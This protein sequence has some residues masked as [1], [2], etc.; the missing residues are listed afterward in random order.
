[1]RPLALKAFYD[2]IVAEQPQ[3]LLV[4]GDIGES[5]SVVRFV[6]E[7]GQLAPI[8]FVLGNH[9]YYR[10]SIRRVRT[11]VAELCSTTPKLVWLT[12]AEVVELALFLQRMGA[13]I[14]LS[15]DRRIVIEGVP[16]LRG[17]S[18]R[19]AGDRLD[20]IEVRRRLV[21]VRT[22]NGVE[23]WVDANLLLSA[24]QM[25]ELAH[26]NRRRIAIAA[27]ADRGRAAGRAGPGDQRRAEHGRGHQNAEP[28]HQAARLSP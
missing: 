9:D 2:Q 26:A 13:H 6:T 3:V 24:Q 16:R 12:S 18:T 27:D 23:G 4:T 19:L 15:P 10:G 17:A 8:Y 1:M 28:G 14:E 21:R 11:E 7:L 22:V 20:V 25:D 5:D